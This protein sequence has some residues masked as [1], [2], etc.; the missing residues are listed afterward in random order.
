[1][2]IRLAQS[3]ETGALPRSRSEKGDDK[4]RRPEGSSGK[5]SMAWAQDNLE[6]VVDMVQQCRISLPQSE[7]ASEICRTLNSRRY[8]LEKY[9]I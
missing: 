2:R 9:G 5:Q 6:I 4:R 7:L 1:V 3:I 8:D